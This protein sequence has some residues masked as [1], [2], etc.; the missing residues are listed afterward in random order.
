MLG[1]REAAQEEKVPPPLPPKQA[2]NSE[3]TWGGG[4][5]LEPHMGPEPQ[6]LIGP[7]AHLSIAGPPHCPDHPMAKLPPHGHSLPCTPKTDP[8]S[9]VFPGPYPAPFPQHSKTQVRTAP[10][11]GGHQAHH[12]LPTVT[13]TAHSISCCGLS[14]QQPA[15]CLEGS[16]WRPQQGPNPPHGPCT[17]GSGAPDRSGR[18]AGETAQALHKASRLEAS[19]PEPSQVGRRRPCPAALLTQVPPQRLTSHF[20]PLSCFS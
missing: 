13:H 15:G 4:R 16:Q 1:G 10:A 6:P 17:D 5:G 7:Q 18:P 2:P 11:P 14:L 9:G 12:P 3:N 20:F 19:W 8:H